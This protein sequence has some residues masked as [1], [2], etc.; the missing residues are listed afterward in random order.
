MFGK[1]DMSALRAA[2][3]VT[4]KG[5]LGIFAVMLVITLLV[6]LFTKFTKS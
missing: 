5:M 2:L 6:F 4:G 3:S 1:I